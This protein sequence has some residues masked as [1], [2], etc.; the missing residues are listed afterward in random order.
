LYLLSRSSQQGS[1]IYA[2]LF[3]LSG[4]SSGLKNTGT[5]ICGQ[6]FPEMNCAIHQL[7]FSFY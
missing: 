4:F 1:S 6:E 3:V 2:A 5:H 7:E